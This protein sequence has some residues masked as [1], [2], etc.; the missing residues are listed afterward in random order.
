MPW[1][2]QFLINHQDHTVTLCGE[3]RER[4]KAIEEV[5]NQARSDHSF[6]VLEGWRN[7]LYPITGSMGQVVMERAGS[8]LFGILSWG[9]HMTAYT[10]TE[11]GM[12]I[13]V[14]RRSPTKQTYPA[15]LDNTVA[16]GISAG[17]L[18]FN[19]LVREAKEEA[20]LPEDMVRERAKACGIVTYFHIRDSRAGGETG[21]LQPEAQYVYDLE[22]PNTVTPKPSDNEVQEFYLWC[23][24]DVQDALRNGE[25]KPNCALVL[26]D[27]FVR[28]GILT[29]ESE[30][31]YVEMVSR[32]H[33]KLP[34]PTITHD[35]KSSNRA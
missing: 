32:L 24:E 16:G 25:F 26:L 15:M 27:F 2:S 20:S 34:F 18:P 23:I 30:E 10:L 3:P 33:R 31:H 14:P 13:W 21:L 12:M 4:S 17:E 1:S 22:L 9:V 8:S 5:L 6:A 19:S 28:H 29:A 11:K 35:S 7:E